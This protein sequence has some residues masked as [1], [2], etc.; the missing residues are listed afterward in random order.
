MRESISKIN[1]KLIWLKR[2]EP[3]Y[4][5]LFVIV[6]LIPVICF[7]FF[8]TVDGPAHLYNSR[9]MVELFKNS[10]SPVNQFINFNPNITPN[11][12]GHYILSFFLIFFPGFIAEKAILIIYL[13][14]LP[15]SIRHLFKTF[16]IKNNYL[17]YL[18]FTFTYSFLF[19]YGFYNF[20]IGLVLLFFGLSLWLKYSRQFSFLK[21]IALMLIS[22]LMCLSHLFVFLVFLIIIFILNIKDFALFIS[23]INTIKLPSPKNYLL[24]LVSILPGII[25]TFQFVFSTSSL[26]A[27][28]TYIPFSNIVISLKYVMPSKGINYDGY[29]IVSRIFYT[30]L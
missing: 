11:C 24:Q 8:P 25:I 9:I 16:G 3:Y 27:N 4:F 22:S 13:A 15:L 26:K 2:L 20:N 30:F 5:Y 14:G 7:R 23:R 1:Q 29:N 17:I 10:N 19:Y 21:V 18:V 6:N 28:S 12:L